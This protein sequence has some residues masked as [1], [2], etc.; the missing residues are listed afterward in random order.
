MNQHAQTDVLAANRAAALS[1]NTRRNLAMGWQRWTEWA[2]SRGLEALPASPEALELFM[3]IHLAEER[4]L[5]WP[6]IA[7]TMW[8]VNSMHRTAGWAAPQDYPH[9]GTALKGLRRRLAGGT[10]KARPL[11]IAE[12]AGMRFGPHP[13]DVRDRAL[14]L[15]GFAACLRESELV[16]LD[17]G[18]VERYR[19]GLLLAIR[20]S[21][22]DPHGR[23][24]EVYV[25]PSQRYPAACPVSALE[26]WTALL[27]AT[28]GAALFR[29]WRGHSPGPRLWPTDVHRIVQRRTRAARL[30]DGYS[31]HS[32]RAGGATWMAENGVAVPDVAR[33]GRWKSYDTV[34]GYCRGDTAAAVRGTY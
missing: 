28:D 8:A 14:L 17:V 4:R 19:D 2:A 32:L 27:P 10:R 34:L 23:G 26:A 3:V 25:A 5:R 6:T 12:I 7:Q 31:G 9:I 24:A 16:A 11:T 22:T 21:K 29:S 20:R 1:A 18:D 33:H 30:G 15:L 13:R